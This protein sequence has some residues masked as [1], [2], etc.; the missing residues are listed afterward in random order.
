ML[1]RSPVTKVT[2]QAEDYSREGFARRGWS[3][4]ACLNDLADRHCTPPVVFAFSIE[5]I[6]SINFTYVASNEMLTF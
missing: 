3:E 5:K 6:A 4:P 1:P 2:Q